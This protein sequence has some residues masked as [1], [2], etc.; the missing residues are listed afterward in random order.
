MWNS[1]PIGIRWGCLGLSAVLTILAGCGSSDEVSSAPPTIG[2]GLCSLPSTSVAHVESALGLSGLED[3]D[4]S[5]FAAFPNIAG[6]MYL[7]STSVT[8]M[9][10][11]SANSS[12]FSS[13]RSGYESA[14]TVPSVDYPGFGDEAYTMTEE[15][16]NCLGVRKGSWSLHMCAAAS[17][18]QLKVLATDVFAD[19]RA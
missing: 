2:E 3:P 16:K 18:D 12:T 17:V 1:N 14:T 11:A 6:C 19:L 15:T 13:D 9:F 10:H 8:I 7:G 5:D 4:Y